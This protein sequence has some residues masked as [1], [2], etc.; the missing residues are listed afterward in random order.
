[1]PVT[2]PLWHGELTVPFVALESANCCSFHTRPIGSYATINLFVQND[3]DEDGAE[4]GH[5]P[6]DALWVHDAARWPM[7]FV[8]EDESY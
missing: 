8:T 4:A 7:P 6:A 1:M 3:P 2:V 5:A